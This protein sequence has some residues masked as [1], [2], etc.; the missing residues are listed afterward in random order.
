[1]SHPQLLSVSTVVLLCLISACSHQQ[2]AVSMEQSTGRLLHPPSRPARSSPPM[3]YI[4]TL[5]VEGQMSSQ[6]RLIIP[7]YT[8]HVAT[9]LP[10]QEGTSEIEPVAFFGCPYIHQDGDDI[11]FDQPSMV[12]VG[13]TIR[14][15]LLSGILIIVANG[16]PG[17]IER[18]KLQLSGPV[19]AQ[20][21]VLISRFTGSLGIQRAEGTDVRES[22]QTFLRNRRVGRGD[23]VIAGLPEEYDEQEEIDLECDEDIV[24]RAAWLFD[25]S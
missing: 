12:R 10:G 21:G 2:D 4:I 23:P 9:P 13:N 5:V 24:A 15:D 25:D 7:L 11:S 20:D 16:I 8:R 3:R 14:G 1:M 22:V 18:D 6:R 17:Y 19:M